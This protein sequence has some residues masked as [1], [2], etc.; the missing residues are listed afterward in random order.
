MTDTEPARSWILELRELLERPGDEALSVG[1]IPQVVLFVPLFVERG[2]LSTVLLEDEPVGAGLPSVRF[3]AAE[4]EPGVDP[5]G[6]VG[7]LARG[8]LGLDPATVLRVGELA[9]VPGEGYGLGELGLRPL[10]AAIPKV[11]AP[12]ASSAFTLA[13]DDFARPDRVEIG[14]VELVDGAREVA[15]YRLGAR[16]IWGR[17]PRCS[18]IWCRGSG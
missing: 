7:A 5:W 1:G 15:I 18:T 11:S 4:L 6:V 10:V 9:T 13:L 8:E 16:S 3:P 2:R 12:E 14:R 17:L